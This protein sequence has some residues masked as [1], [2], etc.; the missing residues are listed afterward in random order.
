VAPSIPA[1]QTCLDLFGEEEGIEIFVEPLLQQRINSAGSIP[2]N[3]EDI[4]SKFRTQPYTT[5]LEDKNWY[6]E[7]GHLTDYSPEDNNQ[8]DRVMKHIRENK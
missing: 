4:L 8:H 6:M 3:L 1:L 5:K 2:S 7:Y